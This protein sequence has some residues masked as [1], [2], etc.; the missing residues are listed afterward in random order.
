MA[1]PSFSSEQR[2][3]FK[4]AFIFATFK[5]RQKITKN[6]DS[7]YIEKTLI[8]SMK[9]L[10]EYVD[11]KRAKKMNEKYESLIFYQL[12][13]RRSIQKWNEWFRNKEYSYTNVTIQQKAY[14]TSSLRRA[15]VCWLRYLK[16]RFVMIPIYE[17]SDN[18]K[19]TFWRHRILAGSFTNWQRRLKS[20]RY[21]RLRA[22]RF[23]HNFKL[24]QLKE[25]MK[26]FQELCTRNKKYKRHI[27][28]SLYLYESRRCRIG[29]SKMS[30]DLIKRQRNQEILLKSILFWKLWRE[31]N[32]IERWKALVAHRRFTRTAK[33]IPEVSSNINKDAVE[34]IMKDGIAT[35]Q[36]KIMFIDKSERKFH[37]LKAYNDNQENE[38]NKHHDVP[39]PILK[40][41]ATTS[42]IGSSSTNFELTTFNSLVKVPP[43]TLPDA[44]SLPIPLHAQKLSV[45]FNITPSTD[46]NKLLYDSSITFSD[47][48]KNSVLQYQQNQLETELKRKQRLNL[49][50][51]IIKFVSEFKDIGLG[52]GLRIP[53]QKI[54]DI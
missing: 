51:D 41:T 30:N 22:K 44:L 26:K 33:L 36:E 18:H 48:H 13:M 42:V 24:K 11:T 1:N 4:Y 21:Q 28:K 39:P 52:L 5:T 37:K 38:T 12:K 14:R 8:R 3:H 19:T 9:F 7:M 32:H 35:W 20:K 54:N 43:R 47:E 31:D 50:K 29:L 45:P 10:W 25:A 23:Y 2:C 53:N 40:T 16:R 34:N 49:A 17:T 6:V 27:V 46:F 15:L